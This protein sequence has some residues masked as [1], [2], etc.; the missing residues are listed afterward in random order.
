MLLQ[1]TS[2]SD[3]LGSCVHVAS[4][5]PAAQATLESGDQDYTKASTHTRPLYG[6]GGSR[7]TDH[8]S[9]A[10]SLRLSEK[11]FDTEVEAQ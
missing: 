4:G 11:A 5:N 7:M 10:A 6:C 8:D 3:A 1:L 9:S 2:K